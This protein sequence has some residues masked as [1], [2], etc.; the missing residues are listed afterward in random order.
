[1]VCQLGGGGNDSDSDDDD[2]YLSFEGGGAGTS[3]RG[4]AGGNCDL[5]PGVDFGLAAGDQRAWRGGGRG[6]WPPFAEGSCSDRS[7][8]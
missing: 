7:S 5:R 4:A 1:M 8:R 3:T 2:E 6:S